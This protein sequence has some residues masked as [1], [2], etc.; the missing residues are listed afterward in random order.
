MIFVIPNNHPRIARERKTIRAMI[1]IYCHGQHG[2][3]DN[4]CTECREL[5][6]Y[7]MRQLDRCPFQEGKTTC[8]NC[9]AHCYKSDMREKIRAVMRYAGPRMLY[10]HPVLTL[11][12]YID[13]RRKEPIRPRR[14]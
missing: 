6:N 9:P 5:L 3:K 11:F 10:Q 1:D 2:T 4:L 7:V 8:V 13:G 12:H 14:K